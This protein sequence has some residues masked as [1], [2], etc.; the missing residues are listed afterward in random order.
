MRKAVMKIGVG[1]L[2]AICAPM[3]LCKVKNRITFISRQSEKPSIDVQ[4]LADYFSVEYPETE[5]RVLVKM[6]KMTPA[7]MLGY[8]GHL[9]SQ[10]HALATSRVVI[11]DGYCISVSVL[12]HKA[13]TSVMQI[14]HSLAAI[15]KFGY[16]T[17]G[18][19]GGHSRDVAETMKMHCNYDY[20]ACPSEATGKLF[21]RA[22]NTDEDRLVYLGLPRIDEIMKDDPE[23]REK[24]RN[25]YSIGEDRRVVLYV[26]TFR[27]GKKVQVRELAEAIDRDK[28]ELVVKLHPV[29][30]EDGD[31]PE[32]IISDDRYSSYEWLKACDAVITDYSALGIEAALTGK[33]VYFYLYDLEEYEKTVGL[34]INPMEEMAWASATDAKTIAGMIDGE[35][36]YEAL[37][38]LRDKYVTVETDNC[39]KR[40]A[41]FIMT[42]MQ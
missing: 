22:M 10:A 14:W 18:S 26:P 7:G 2:K 12:K 28:N 38:K 42:L 39:T 36:D 15:K 9:F 19:E 3:S 8:I 24:I 23:T 41:D 21:C 20:L 33:P 11:V 16:Q 5:C 17:I 1:L 37:K 13:E 29:Y 34:N 30:R 25:E 27:K 31:V 32:G 35:Y 4:M 6:L 40:M